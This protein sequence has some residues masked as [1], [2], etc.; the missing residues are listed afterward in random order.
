MKQTKLYHTIS[1][2]ALLTVTPVALTS[3]DDDTDPAPIAATSQLTPGTVS[4]DA[5]SFT[6]APV[7]NAVQY[8]CQL[9]D[10]EGEVVDAKVTKSTEVT[11]TGLKAATTYTLN[12]WAYAVP[13]GPYTTSE[14]VTIT[15]TTSALSM[16]AAPQLTVENRAGTVTASWNPVEGAT[17]YKVTLSRDGQTVSTDEEAETSHYWSGLEMGNYIVTVQAQST[18]P[19][20]EPSSAPA[21]GTFV[22]NRAEIWRASGT[23]TRSSDGA[24][25]GAT[26]VAY[27]DDTYQLLNW[28][29][30][31]A[32]LDF[33]VDPTLG[34]EDRFSLIGDYTYDDA[35][36]SYYVP[37]GLASPSTVSV[38]PWYGYSDLTGNK[39]AGEL[40]LYIYDTFSNDIFTWDNS[41]A[42]ITADDLTGTW[43][44]VQ[45]GL[46]YDYDTDSWPDFTSDYPV[47]VT[48]I[49]DTT[50]SFDGII[51]TDAP[52]IGILDS[53]S[54]TITFKPQEWGYYTFGAEDDVNG[55]VIATID[56][57]GKIRLAGF[58]AWYAGYYYYYDMEVIMSR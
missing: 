41:V 47:T 30:G 39:N 10:A 57:D 46:E 22:I 45:T 21:Q 12:V 5:L 13:G 31:D 38:Y 34:E 48:K 19:G 15:A 2:A 55:K 51:W 40:S 8:G 7:D 44:S 11:F 17:S 9:T 16:L 50:L 18:T 35:T 6:W 14:P 33:A 3:C 36:G 32:S 56:E 29:G 4:Y 20:Y 24:K 25:W 43:N 23:Y 37:T 52:V 26:L 53:A 1:L 49:D 28:Y 54:R 27:S 58:T 42:G